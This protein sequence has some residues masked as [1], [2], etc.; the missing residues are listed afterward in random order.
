VTVQFGTATVAGDVARLDG[1]EV[2]TE[3]IAQCHGLRCDL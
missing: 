2:T 3:L 1:D